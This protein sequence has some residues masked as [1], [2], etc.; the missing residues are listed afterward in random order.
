[1]MI[2]KKISDFVSTDS[3][4]F[5]KEKILFVNCNKKKLKKVH[6]TQ[7]PK[8]CNKK[9]TKE[10]IA[11]QLLFYLVNAFI[12]ILKVF[13][14]QL[15]F[16]RITTKKA[17]EINERLGCLKKLFSKFISSQI[18][19]FSFTKKTTSHQTGMLYK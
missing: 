10:S 15:Y 9:I 11:N 3:K 6:F 19:R 17:N 5:N 14:I 16:E 7:M 18:S 8:P 2:N 1:M 12:W 4:S 13:F